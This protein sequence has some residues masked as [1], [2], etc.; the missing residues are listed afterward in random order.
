MSRDSVNGAT[1]VQ[2]VARI[3][4]VLRALEDEPD[5][6]SLSAIAD[7]S[8]LARSTVQRLVSALSTEGFVAPVGPRGRVRLGATIAR[9]GAA[10]RRDL[11]E[12]LSDLLRRLGEKLE[13]T[14]DLAI[15]DGSQV[16]V[17]D[18]ISSNQPLRAVSAPGQ[19]LPVHAT[20][21][22]KA[23]LS[24]LPEQ[25]VKKMLPARLRTYTPQTLSSRAALLRQLSDIRRSGLAVVRDEYTPG[26]SGI[27]GVVYDIDGSVASIGI[28]VPSVRFD[29]TEKKL[30]RALLLSCREATDTL[31]GREQTGASG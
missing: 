15:L 1:G 25:E 13:E 12:S 8:G 20:A 30:G 4:N 17:V 6:L 9:L 23:L 10:S 22:G 21:G 29:R 31:G 27:A 24:I 19:Q 28:P 3:A 7:R 5:G 11:R 26:I 16:R 2:V 14:V 18:Q